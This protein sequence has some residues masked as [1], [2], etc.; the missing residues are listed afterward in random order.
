[1]IKKESRNVSRVM[2]HERVRKNVFGTKE[3]PRLNVFR[4]NQEIYAQITDDETQTTLVAS[5]RVM[6]NIDNGGNIEGALPRGGYT[7]FGRAD[8]GIDA[9]GD[10]KTLCGFA[11]NA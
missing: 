3:M 6:L 10:Q 9:A 7:Y 2:R 5:S 11:P 8:G 4:S 1:M